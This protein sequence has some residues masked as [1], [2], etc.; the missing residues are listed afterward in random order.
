[1][2]GH[3]TPI[4]M[5]SH[6]CGP[7]TGTVEV[8]G[9]KSI[10]HR[11]LILG[12]MA[13]GETR[14]SGLLEGEDVLD[15]AKAMRA[16]GAE[17]TDHGGGEWTVHG[18]GVGGFAE[19]DQVIDC[20]NSGTGVRLIMGAMATSPITATFTGDASL[21][22]RPMARVTDPLALFGTQSVGRSGGR[23]PMTI[24]GAAD[25]TPVRYEV[26]VPSAQVKSAVLLA[27]LN[28]PG[29]TVV[30]EKEATRDHSERMLAG[31]GAEITVEDTEE[32][33]VITLTGRP[34]LKPQVIAV[35]RDPSSAAFPVCAALITPGSDVLVPGIG[36]NPTR[37]GLF[38]TLR[39][40]G[41][42]LTYENEREEGGEPVADLRAK[43]SPNMKGITVPPERAASM[44]DEYPVL[45]VVAA[46]ATGTMMMGGVK[47]LR[48][49]ESDRI[50]AMARGLRANGVTVNEGD[51]WWSVEGLGIG[52]VPGAGT[53]ESF[54]DHRIAMSFMVMG[55]GAQK[56]VRVDDGG[57]IAT[58][59]PIFE[60]LM[61]SLGAKVERS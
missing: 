42:D 40:M 61:A 14:I 46:N 4:P 6:P 41:A 39:E 9:D 55:M 12:A 7:L 58:S 8:P 26:P 2:S 3:G 28:A 11:S 1:M 18:V 22:K 50:D 5:T 15:T 43:Y 29:K 16:F 33:R 35:P 20:G 25:P 31:F 60:P 24:V 53:C 51:D 30:I 49:K 36:L 38:T 17:V 37:A 57:P 52:N 19:P 45:S 56:P 10:S 21:N 27:G 34:E 47:E 48:V 44:I 54:L 32:G 59:F 13:V 23:L